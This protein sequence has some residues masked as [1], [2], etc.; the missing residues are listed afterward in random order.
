M[1]RPK[2]EAG[3]QNP[4]E[5]VKV[6]ARQQMAELGTAGISLR[7]IARVMGITAPAIYNYYPSLDDLITALIVDAFVSLAE[8][9][10]RAGAQE[11]TNLQKVRAMMLAYRTWSVEHPADFQLIFGNP[12]PGYVAPAAVTAP[13]ARRPFQSI[14]YWL[15]QAQQQGEITLPPAYQQVPSE[16]AAHLAQW[17]QHTG[18]EADDALFCLLMTG[19]TRIHGLVILELNH[20]LQ[21]AIGD[22][23]ALFHYEVQ[24]FLGQL[25]RSPP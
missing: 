18:I 17:K 9:I 25:S 5:A 7:A 23:A 19:W 2:R 22:A 21:P 14:Y 10:K 20:H 12:I 3:L 8:T 15:S 6:V 13:L 24:A 16:I 11:G 1:P 4:T